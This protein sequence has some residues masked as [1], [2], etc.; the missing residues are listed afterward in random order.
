[1]SRHIRQSPVDGK[2]RRWELLD[3]ADYRLRM[4]DPEDAD[5]TL[6]DGTSCAEKVQVCTGVFDSKAKAKRDT[7]GGRRVG[8]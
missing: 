2:W 5:R 3:A 6:S 8:K 7:Y 4:Q 1:M